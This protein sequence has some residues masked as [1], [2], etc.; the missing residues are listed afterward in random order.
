[1][2]TLKALSLLGAL[3]ALTVIAQADPLAVGAPAPKITAP[4]QDG[5]PVD[6]AKVYA[7]GTTLVYFYPKADTPGCTAEGWSRA[8]CSFQGLFKLPF[9]FAAAVGET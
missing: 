9:P 2:K 1:M 7:K 6:F 3:L 4:D 8:V 5:K